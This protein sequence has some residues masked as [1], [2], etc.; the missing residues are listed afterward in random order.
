M[1]RELEKRLI[2]IRRHLHQ[3]PEL[4]NE[5]FETTKSIQKW[6]GEEGIE[7]RNT[8]LKTGVFADIK[9]GKPGLTV[10]I[11]A[12]IDALPIEEQTG[13]PFA[14]KVKG[15]MHACGH[16][17]H[18]AAVIG[19]A[20]LLKECQSELNG[21]VRLIFQP[22]EES[23][24]GAAHVIK[25]GQI[26]DVAA[27]IGLHNKPNLPVGTIG[28]KEGPLMAAVDRFQIVLQGK[29]SHAAI[30]HSGK[31]PIAAAAQLIT[32]LQT[33]VSRNVSPLESAVVSVTR[34]TGGNTWNVIPGN[35]TLEGTI[36]TFESTIREEIK[37][38][39]YS[40]VNH[41]AAA[42]S[43]EATIDW[44]PGPPALHNHPAVT[45]MASRSALGQS[46]HV[47][48]PEPS[49]GGEDF[50]YYLQHIPGTFAFFGTNGNEDWHHP[51]FTVDENSIIKAAHFLFESAK[52]L[53]YNHGK[54]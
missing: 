42:F 10:A 5:E 2:S 39:F 8:V 36:R 48:N 17:F 43:Q 46:L 34:I 27:I 51:A 52:D 9:G 15:V 21:T 19:A 3:Y 4:S 54:W 40:I 13:L 6:L 28:I 47:I 24:G 33:I 50:A 38:K 1:S 30:P 11:R 31:D 32:A 53:L 7:I 49:M 26:G 29:G 44:F 37:D 18:T 25:D 35:V 14:S 45:E 22:A 23:G 12:D 16:D 41:I 20:Y